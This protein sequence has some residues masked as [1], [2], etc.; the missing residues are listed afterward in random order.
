MGARLDIRKL[1]IRSGA[2][3]AVRGIDLYVDEGEVLGLVGESGS[4][5]SATALAILGLLGPAAQVEGEILWQGS[6][7]AI[8]LLRQPAGALR[9]LRGSEIAMIFQEPMTALNPVMTIGRQVAESARAHASSWTGRDAK[10]RAIAALESV[11]ILDAARRYGDYPHQFS[12]GQRQR[13]LIAMAL[14]NKPRLLIADEPTTALD[15]TVQAQVM[16]L[17]K[18][19][20]R[21]H[22]LAMLFISHDLAVVGQVA[23]RVA[24]MR[25]GQV[26]ETGPCRLLLTNPENPYTKSLLAAVPTLKTDRNRPLARMGDATDAQARVYSR[27]ETP[28]ER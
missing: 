18:D 10:R 11:A 7:G 22:G 28:T 24:V 20:Q 13:I 21:Q 2:A 12:G 25:A 1:Q 9:R 4:G 23:S 27:H 6:E 8:D 19:L 26:V 17:L 5:K 15:V 16:E 14:I 3:E